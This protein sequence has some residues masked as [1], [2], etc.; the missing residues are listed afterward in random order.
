MSFG[1]HLTYVRMCTTQYMHA[2]SVRHCMVVGV[3]V[4]WY[5]MTSFPAALAPVTVPQTCLV[6]RPTCWSYRAV[7]KV[8]VIRASNSSF[9]DNAILALSALYSN[10]AYTRLC[11]LWPG[12]RG[13]RHLLLLALNT[14]FKMTHYSHRR[15]TV[16]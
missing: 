15:Y 10:H 2:C 9:E 1:C 5:H 13:K 11:Y 12:W 6:S 16:H 14:E 7:L 3:T 4:I 8:S